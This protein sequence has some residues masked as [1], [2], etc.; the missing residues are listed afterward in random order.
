MKYIC[1]QLFPNIFDVVSITKAQIDRL[2][3]VVTHLTW[4]TY[5]DSPTLRGFDATPAYW[6]V[7]ITSISPEARNITNTGMKYFET[8]LPRRTLHALAMGAAA[9]LQ[10]LYDRALLFLHFVGA[11]HWQHD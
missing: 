2:Q 9:L 6:L 1:I 7:L 10:A 8:H 11:W 4:G 5:V 3:E